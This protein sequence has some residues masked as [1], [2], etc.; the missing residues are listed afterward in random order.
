MK[1]MKS[2]IA[3]IF[4]LL[5]ATGAFAQDNRIIVNMEVRGQVFSFRPVPDSSYFM[6]ATEVTQAQYEAVMGENPS[7]F[8]GGD[9]PVEQVSWYDAIYFCN[10]LSKLAGYSPIYAVNGE[11]DVTKWDYI[12]NKGNRL[13]GTVTQD[14]DAAGFRLPMD[15]EWEYAAWGGQNCRFSGSDSIDE[16]GWYAGNSGHTTHQWRRR[17]PTATACMT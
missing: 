9:L 1:R 11:T 17:R 2:L 6:G 15:A 8:K 4:G 7:R 13:S 14:M 12:P 16:V 5:F 10:K 3:L